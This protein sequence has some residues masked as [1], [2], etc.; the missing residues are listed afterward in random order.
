MTK[1][2]AY[3][4]FQLTGSLISRDENT[5]RP[6]PLGQRHL[7]PIRNV[8]ERLAVKSDQRSESMGTMTAMMP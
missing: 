6:F 1:S 8:G 7:G 4:V 3:T 5:K 2:K